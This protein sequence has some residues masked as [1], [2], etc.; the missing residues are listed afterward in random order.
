MD[1][2]YSNFIVTI[3]YC[4]AVDMGLALN[5][6]NPVDREHCCCGLSLLTCMCLFH[7][8]LWGIQASAAT[9]VY[10][11]QCATLLS[12]LTLGKVFFP[13]FGTTCTNWIFRGSMLLAFFPHFPILRFG[14]VTASARLPL[15]ITF[16]SHLH[17]PWGLAT[18]QK[19]QIAVWRVLF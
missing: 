6:D 15:V 12:Y 8:F 4:R 16:L 1:P 17:T 2:C 9:W 5:I 7:L 19:G 18:W 11:W 3:I 14:L 13:S 10:S